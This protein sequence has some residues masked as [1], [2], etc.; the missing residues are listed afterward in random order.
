M[1]KGQVGLVFYKLALLLAH[2]DVRSLQA[3]S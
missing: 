2:G 1:S 3:H